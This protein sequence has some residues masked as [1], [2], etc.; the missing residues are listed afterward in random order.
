MF[1]LIDNYSCVFPQN[2]PNKP[3]RRWIIIRNSRIYHACVSFSES[4]VKPM[5]LNGNKWYTELKSDVTHIDENIKGVHLTNVKQ[6]FDR[7]LFFF[8]W[9]KVCILW[10]F[11][12]KCICHRTPFFNLYSIWVHVES[13]KYKLIGLKTPKS[14]EFAIFWTNSCQKSLTMFISSC[15]NNYLMEFLKIGKLKN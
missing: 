13:L 5:Y 15:S 2:R 8:L 11:K 3:T 7:K 10:L 6:L 9:R 1:V 14:S 4:A 12:K